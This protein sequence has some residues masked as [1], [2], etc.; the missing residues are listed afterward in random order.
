MIDQSW[1]MNDPIGKKP[2]DATAPP[3]PKRDAV[4]DAVNRCLYELS[5][6]SAGE[7]DVRDY[8]DIAVIGYG[9]TVG[10]AFGG[11]LSNERLVPIS[12]V[13]DEP[14]RI[15]DRTK[16]VAD[17]AGGVTTQNIKVP[18]WFDP[19]ANGG[20]PMRQALEEVKS[21]LG[22]WIS[23]HGDNYPPVV[24]NI[25]DGEATDGDPTTDAEEIRKLATTDGN[26]LVFNSH[27]SGVDAS[28]VYYPDRPDG[29][30]PRSICQSTV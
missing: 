3:K 4:A 21:I 5:I 16:Q 17:G 27:V 23:A 15:E 13:A 2:G 11:S 30:P 26:V 25:T 7:A 20:T 8:F 19:K 28:P 10:P 18:I 9:E 24:L 12:R 6:R 29:L 1:S 14:L 22:D